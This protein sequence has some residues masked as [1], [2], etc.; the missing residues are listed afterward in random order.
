MIKNPP[1]ELLRI[2]DGRFMEVCKRSRHI[3]RCCSS[4]DR[5]RDRR[6]DCAHPSGIFVSVDEALEL[7]ESISNVVSCR[8]VEDAFDKSGYLAGICPNCQ[9]NKTEKG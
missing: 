9:L 2:N 5:L 6:N 7:A 3:A 1:D 4:L 8:V